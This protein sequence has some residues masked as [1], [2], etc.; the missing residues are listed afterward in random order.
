MKIMAPH[1]FSFGEHPFVLLTGFDLV[2]ISAL[3]ESVQYFGD[4][5]RRRLFT[6]AELDYAE[7]G[8][9]H[10]AERLA[11]RFAAKEATIKALNL[12]DIGTNWRHIEVSK[13]P[14]GACEL[15]LHGA[16]KEMAEQLQV[17]QMA[18][19]LSHD[20]DYAGAFV[21]ILCQRKNSN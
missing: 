9:S 16:V 10:W 17:V 20:G 5:F 15:V 2:K 13:L 8:G 21:N 12:A 6:S 14:D 19:S 11:A 18:L 3:T 4:K 7:S 1:T